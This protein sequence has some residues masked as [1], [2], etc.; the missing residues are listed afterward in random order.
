MEEE[1]RL[2]TKSDLKQSR[3]YAVLGLLSR[4]WLEAEEAIP[5]EKRC[6]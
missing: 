5:R 3:G 6:L 4:R 2:G 1:V